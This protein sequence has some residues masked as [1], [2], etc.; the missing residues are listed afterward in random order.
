MLTGYLR[1]LLFKQNLHCQTLVFFKFYFKPGQNRHP[2]QIYSGNLAGVLSKNPSEANYKNLPQ[3]FFLEMVHKPWEFF[4]ISWSNPLIEFQD[5]RINSC[6]IPNRSF[7]KFPGGI[8]T[9]ILYR[10]L[11]TS[12]KCNHRGILRRNFLKGS[13]DEVSWSVKCG[14]NKRSH[15]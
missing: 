2:L 10:N 8:P 6:R 7:W 12:I 1:M 15:F 13:S 4:R 3:R 14:G 11:G 5:S 9:K